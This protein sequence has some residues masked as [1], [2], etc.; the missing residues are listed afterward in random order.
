V[1]WEE[2][3]SILT[4]KKKFRIIGATDLTPAGLIET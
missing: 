2:I 3:G 1:R 4:G